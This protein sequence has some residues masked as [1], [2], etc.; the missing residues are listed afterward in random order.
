LVLLHGW[1]DSWLTW[2][3]VV[4]ELEKHHRV[5]APMLPG[6]FGAAPWQIPEPLHISQLVDAVEKQLDEAG[7]TT[8]HLAG[9][10]LGGW[11]ALELAARGRAESVIAICPA[12]GWVSHDR[13]ERR[14]IR[15]F[16]QG[17]F[18]A[19]LV[20]PKAE[21]LARRP[22][23]RTYAMK[24]LVAYP[25]RTTP[26][27]LVAGIRGA[28]RCDLTP[29]LIELIRSEGFGELGPID[30]PVHIAWGTKDRL[31]RW[32]RCYVRFPALVPEAE[33]VP[34]EGL[35]HLAQR[36]APGTVARAILEVTRGAEAIRNLNGQAAA[37]SGA[38]LTKKTAPATRAVS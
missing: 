15:Y 9:N 8:A 17:R 20:A 23:L 24:D 34:L 18:M 35:G 12:G 31:I 16:K 11:L 25:G 2:L 37:A 38:G 22:R 19:R 6:H 13:L 1:T 27:A 4:P 3:Q 26:E 29:A 7:I 33:W 10:S 5:F 21:S 32:P 30:C 36:D 28:A 14:G